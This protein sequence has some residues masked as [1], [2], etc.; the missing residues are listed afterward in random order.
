MKAKSIVL[1]A[2]TVM[3]SGCVTTTSVSYYDQKP[4][5][6]R[7]ELDGSYVIRVGAKD[8]NAARAMAEARK[9]AVYEVIFNGVPSISGSVN[10]LK[11]I[12]L[13]VNAKDKYQDYFNAF[14]AQEEYLK[15]ISKEDKRTASTDFYRNYQQIQ[16]VTNVTVNVAELKNRLRKD[17]IIKQ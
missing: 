10:A 8:R 15:Y 4:Q 17:N 16:C 11:P 6:L 13:E 5:V 7:S 9:M 3:L 2:L 12:L 14:F 1:A